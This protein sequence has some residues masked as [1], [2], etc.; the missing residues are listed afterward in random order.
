M[1]ETG[2]SYLQRTQAMLDAVYNKCYHK[3]FKASDNNIFFDK[4][5]KEIEEFFQDARKD[6]EMA[7]DNLT[8]K[9]G[10]DLENYKLISPN[11]VNTNSQSSDLRTQYINEWAMSG[12]FAI[13]KK[14]NKRLLIFRDFDD[15]FL[16]LLKQI[17]VSDL[18]NY[19][20]LNVLDSCINC[21]TILKLDITN[22]K[23]TTIINNKNSIQSSIQNIHNTVSFF[24]ST[25]QFAQGAIPTQNTIAILLKEKIALSYNESGDL[26][27]LGLFSPAFLNT[28][29]SEKYCIRHISESEDMIIIGVDRRTSKRWDGF[30]TNDSEEKIIFDEDDFSYYCGKF[31]TEEFDKIFKVPKKIKPKFDFDEFIDF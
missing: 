28:I 3:I 24:S 19:S 6:V 18:V 14:G 12:Y 15:D 26:L 10:E 2:F 17:C 27:V 1:T 7:I 31:S 22:H 8:N 16:Q 11:F 23:R 30:G 21:D 13:M 5:R 29:N 4:Y 9:V 20:I 25:S